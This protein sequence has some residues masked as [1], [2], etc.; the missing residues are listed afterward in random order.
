MNKITDVLEA[1]EDWEYLAAELGIENGKRNTIKSDCKIDSSGSV[2][3]CYRRKLVRTY[4]DSTALELVKVVENIAVALDGMTKRQQADILRRKFGIAGEHNSSYSLFLSYYNCMV[5]P[6][7]SPVPQPDTSNDG[8]SAASPTSDSK[9]G[10]SQID[11][12]LLEAVSK[13]VGVKGVAV[14]ILAL[15]AVWKLFEYCIYRTGNIIKSS[16]YVVYCHSC[17]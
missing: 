5:N 15:V 6:A 9:A 7:E 11:T 2:A 3:T 4:C 1:V 16:P 12:P 14:G 17:V 8:S 13:F 10:A